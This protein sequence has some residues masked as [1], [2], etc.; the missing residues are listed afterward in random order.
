MGTHLSAL[1]MG[2]AL[3][4]VIGGKEDT[5][6]RF[7]HSILTRRGL[8]DLEIDV[9]PSVSSYSYLIPATPI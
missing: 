1:T 2:C 9:R 6:V 5:K 7:V 4:K 3:E 8:A